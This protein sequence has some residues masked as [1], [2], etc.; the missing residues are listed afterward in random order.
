MR[1]GERPA[2]V[3]KNEFTPARVTVCIVTH[4][5]H[6]LGYYASRLD[7]LRL[8]LRSLHAHTP[9][10]AVDVMVLDNGS[11]DE[12]VDDLR[13]QLRAGTINYLTLLDKNIGKLR[14]LETMCGAAPGELIAYGDDDVLYEAGWLEAQLQ[15][16]AAFPRVGMVSA[17]PV[18]KQFS[19]GN[20][21][22]PGYLRAHPDVTA[23]HGH[24]IPDDWELEYLRSTGQS[25]DGLE[26]V[27]RK[28][29]D[30]LLERGGITAYSTASHFQFVAPKAVLQEGFRFDVGAEWAS[31]DRQLEMAIDRLGYARLSTNG[32]FVRHIGNVIDAQMLAAAPDLATDDLKV[33][34]ESAGPVRTAARLRPIRALL[35]R[36]HEW[37]Y[38]RL[39]E[40]RG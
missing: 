29:T 24:F 23:K 36:L 40:P 18:R 5:P 10:G 6:Q 15:L 32:R 13:R 30:I 4:I 38:T 9:R 20:E 1:L 19:Y 16:M 14:A 2:F 31:D 17:R 28:R 12:V 3:R 33:W 35:R 26:D 7:V 21:Y 25:A 11:C 22:L 34:R 37:T 39:H 27:K 8:S